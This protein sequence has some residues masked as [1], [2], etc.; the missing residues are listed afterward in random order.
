M[1]LHHSNLLGLIIIAIFVTVLAEVSG[2]GM[3]NWFL[4]PGRDR[5]FSFSSRVQVG[6]RFRPSSSTIRIR[7]SISG[8]RH[9][10]REDD[11]TSPSSV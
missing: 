5:K 6:S 9:P 8:S 10:Q 7:G 1:E 11:H 4:I 3:G 2:C